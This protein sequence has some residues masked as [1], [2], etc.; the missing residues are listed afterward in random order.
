MEKTDGPIN[1]SDNEVDQGE[2]E[3]KSF[4]RAFANFFLLLISAI[5]EPEIGEENRISHDG[6]NDEDILDEDPSSEGSDTNSNRGTGGDG[7]DQ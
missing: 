3:D 4:I 7:G 6:S 5:R 1:Y 2:D